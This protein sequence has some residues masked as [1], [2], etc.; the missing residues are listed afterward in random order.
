M[1]KKWFEGIEVLK[2]FKHIDSEHYL[3]KAQ[4]EGKKILAEGAQG[5]LLDIDFGSYP[6]VTSSNTISAGACT[7]LGIAPNI[8]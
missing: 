6:F 7:G 8:R 3:Y 5:T 1:R 4:N 2:S